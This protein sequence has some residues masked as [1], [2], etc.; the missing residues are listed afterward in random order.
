MVS[1]HFKGKSILQTVPYLE[2][3]VI[4]LQNTAVIPNEDLTLVYTSADLKDGYSLSKTISEY[5]H[6]DPY[7]KSSDNDTSSSS[8]L[9]INRSSSMDISRSIKN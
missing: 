9:K 7:Y 6:L 4:P 2:S 1:D 5:K 3:P 8:T